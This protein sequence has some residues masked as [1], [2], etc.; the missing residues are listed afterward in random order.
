MVTDTEVLT[1]QEILSPQ[2]ALCQQKVTNAA[3]KSSLRGATMMGS[4]ISLQTRPLRSY[5]RIS[6]C[7]SD[8]LDLVDLILTVVLHSHSAR[9]RISTF[10]LFAFYRAPNMSSFDTIF[11]A[12]TICKLAKLNAGG[13]F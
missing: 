8:P 1:M 9:K 2:K 5:Q 12:C 13:H 10:H 6:A 7:K 11:C 4:G 3:S